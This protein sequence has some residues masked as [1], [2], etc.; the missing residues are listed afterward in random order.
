MEI[1]TVGQLV[2]I[3]LSRFTC[4][5]GFKGKC[6]DELTAFIEFEQLQDYFIK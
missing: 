5:R 2:E 1:C 6:M 3:P 4:F